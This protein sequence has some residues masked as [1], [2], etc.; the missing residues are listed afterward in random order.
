[1]ALTAHA[2]EGEREK[3][4]S[5]GMDD[6]L[7]KPITRTALEQMLRRFLALKEGLFDRR[8]ALEQLDGDEELLQELLAL[9]LDEA[10]KRLAA[11]EAGR[12]LGEPDQVRE[13]AHALKGMAAQIGAAGLK[14]QAASIERK[15][16]AGEI[17]S[18]AI[19]GLAQTLSK[20]L[21]SLQE[22]VH[23]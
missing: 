1:V 10:P 13:A 6:Y 4:L 18:A 15:A 2:G 5:C 8:L 11:L 7:A 21:A 20:L 14:D 19:Q 17:D 22:E 12:R 3:C 23:G 9:F 16:K